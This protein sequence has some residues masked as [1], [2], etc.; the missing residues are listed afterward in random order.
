MPGTIALDDDRLYFE[1]TVCHILGV[2]SA[3]LADARTDGRLRASKVGR[4]RLYKGA[5]LK[6][7][8]EASGEPQALE[9]AAC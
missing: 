8:I 3:V 2:T 1:P 6:E 7:W 9:A 5:W 4:R